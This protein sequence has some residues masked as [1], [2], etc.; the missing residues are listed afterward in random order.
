MFYVAHLCQVE[1]TI[2]LNGVWHTGGQVCVDLLS[3]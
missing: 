3:D 1:V 2:F